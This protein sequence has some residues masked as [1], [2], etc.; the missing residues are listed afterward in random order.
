MYYSTIM[1]IRSLIQLAKNQG[2]RRVV[3]FLETLGKNQFICLVQLLKATHIPWLLVPSHYFKNSNV[4][5]LNLSDFY[6]P[7]TFTKPL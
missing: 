4:A 2:A 7:F 6:F 1:E 5:S 3:F